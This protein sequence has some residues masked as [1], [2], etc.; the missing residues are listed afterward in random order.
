MKPTVNNLHLIRHGD[1]IHIN[2]PG[3]NE[4]A[5]VL[6]WQC[7]LYIR[8]KLFSNTI[9]HALQYVHTSSKKYVR[10]ITEYVNPPWKS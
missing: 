6:H 4:D 1:L 5:G 10:E 8:D 3:H 7:L 9:G 2:N